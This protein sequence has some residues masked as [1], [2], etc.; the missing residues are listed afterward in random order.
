MLVTPVLSIT[1]IDAAEGMYKK[2]LTPS[3]AKWRLIDEGQY[4][5]CKNSCTFASKRA[6]V[7]IKKQKILYIYASVV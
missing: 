6:S 4:F 2:K 5:F 1:I 7:T 3:R